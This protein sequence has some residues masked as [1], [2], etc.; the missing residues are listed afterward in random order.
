VKGSEFDVAIVIGKS[1]IVVQSTTRTICTAPRW[2]RGVGEALGDPAL[3]HQEPVA[4]KA[5]AEAWLSPG[6][7]RG[8]ADAEAAER[9]VEHRLL[10]V[11]RGVTPTGSVAEFLR[12]TN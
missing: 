8:I 11:T 4:G 5:V 9:P 6:M 12:S 3:L 2:W 7:K 10:A 1:G